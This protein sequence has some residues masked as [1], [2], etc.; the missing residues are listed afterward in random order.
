M[1]DGILFFIGEA[2]AGKDY[3][4]EKLVEFNPTKFNKMLQVTTREPRSNETHG[5]NGYFISKEEFKKNIKSN[6]M[7]DWEII[8]RTQN[9]YGNFTDD[10]VSNKINIITGDPERL[11][12]LLKNKVFSNKPIWI[13]YLTGSIETRIQR[14]LERDKNSKQK[15]LEARLKEEK[16]VQRLKENNIHKYQ[17]FLNDGVSF[18]YFSKFIQELLDLFPAG[19]L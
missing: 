16:F 14:Y 13:I 10:Y 17:L 9:Y 8:E 6:L 19:M 7:I 1:K 11:K 2:G 3:L 5:I 15:E 4:S 12:S 18:D